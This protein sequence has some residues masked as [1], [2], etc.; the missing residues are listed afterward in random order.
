M[1]L[2]VNRWH[3]MALP[4]QFSSVLLDTLAFKVPIGMMV[5]H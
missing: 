1:G 3:I 4:A 2:E 5:I